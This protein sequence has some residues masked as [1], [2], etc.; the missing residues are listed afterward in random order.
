MSRNA[1][2]A[3]V[4]I[5]IVAVIAVVLVVARPDDQGA[6][7]AGANGG[8]A[9]LTGETLDGASFDLADYRGK[10]VVVNFFASWCGPC[11]SEAPD[12]AAFARENPD[13]AFVGI[14]TGDDLGDGKAFVEKYGL[15]YP[16]VFDPD[17]T[18]AGAWGVDGI[19][20]TVFLDASGVE[21]D[22]VVGAADKATFEQSLQSVQ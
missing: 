9:T 13:V 2:T 17:G 4:I 6:G 11:N 14:D 3:L 8:P 18:I 10:P 21:R 20:T 12:L 22:R 7:A 15:D 19:P 5:A 1:I 16:M